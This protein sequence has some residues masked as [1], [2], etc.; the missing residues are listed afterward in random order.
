MCVICLDYKRGAITRQ[1]A[2]MNLNEMLRVAAE[3]GEKIFNHLEELEQ[4]L[5]DEEAF[6]DNPETD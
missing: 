6:C 1:E 4:S 3:E 5:L 2:M